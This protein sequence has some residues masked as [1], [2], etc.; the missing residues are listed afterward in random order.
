M[1][2]EELITQCL[3]NGNIIIHCYYYLLGR[4][5]SILKLTTL[6]LGFTWREILPISQHE[7]NS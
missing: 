4:H 7:F 6:E 1:I 2:Y 5:S 3:I